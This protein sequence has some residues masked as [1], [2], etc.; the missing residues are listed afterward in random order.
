M[1]DDGTHGDIKAGD[2]IFSVSVLP[3]Q[4]TGSG[5]KKLTVRA[6]NLIGASSE[7]AITLTVE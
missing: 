7:G 3:K 5:S 2:I 4:G 1:W 6:V